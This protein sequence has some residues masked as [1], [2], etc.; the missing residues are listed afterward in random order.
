MFKIRS[1]KPKALHP[2]SVRVCVSVCVC[3]CVW[4]VGVCFSTKYQVQGK[5]CGEVCFLQVSGL[6]L[7]VLG[8]GFT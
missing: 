3:V 8:L 5:D 7:L 2:L 6:I 4:E 1:R